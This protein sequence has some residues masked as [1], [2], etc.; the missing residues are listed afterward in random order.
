MVKEKNHISSKL[1][2]TYIYSNNVIH[3][4]TKNLRINRSKSNLLMLTRKGGTEVHN[5]LLLTLALD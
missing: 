5:H 3:P 4:I 2:M 1:H